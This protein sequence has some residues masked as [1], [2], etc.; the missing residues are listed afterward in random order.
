M[1]QGWTVDSESVGDDGAMWEVTG[2]GFTTSSVV[3]AAQDDGTRVDHRP[4][5]RGRQLTS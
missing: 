2:N 4:V 5:S 3:L 1:A